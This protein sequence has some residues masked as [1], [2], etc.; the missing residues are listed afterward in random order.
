LTLLT[1]KVSRQGFD[2]ILSATSILQL[3]T[4]AN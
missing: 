1:L 3:P 2:K 4:S